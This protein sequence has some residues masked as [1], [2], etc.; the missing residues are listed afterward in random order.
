[1]FELWCVVPSSQSTAL[2]DSRGG[3]NPRLTPFKDL[4]LA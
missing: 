1:M 4:A 2:K 3:L